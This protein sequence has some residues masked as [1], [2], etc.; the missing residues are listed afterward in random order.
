MPNILTRSAAKCYTGGIHRVHRNQ[1][2]KLSF[3]NRIVNGDAYVEN[4][5]VVEGETTISDP[6]MVDVLRARS[7]G[8]ALAR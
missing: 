1:K 7:R 8:D 6:E 3:T 4:V 5:K 2:V